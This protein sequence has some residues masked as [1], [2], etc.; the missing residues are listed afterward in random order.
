MPRYQGPFLS[1]FLVCLFQRPAA[2]WRRLE[3]KKHCRPYIAFQPPRIPL[4][5]RN[6]WLHRVWADRFCK[7]HTN[8]GQELRNLVSCN[9]QPSLNFFSLLHEYS[10]AGTTQP[11]GSENRVYIECTFGRT[12]AWHIGW[13]SFDGRRNEGDPGNTPQFWHVARA[14]KRSATLTMVRYKIRQTNQRTHSVGGFVLHR[15]MSIAQRCGAIRAPL[16]CIT[17]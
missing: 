13:Y 12:F 16:Y 6:T 1:T 4:T 3:P 14:T 5:I 17:I 8:I 9:R 11:D 2:Q 15:R 7:R 10:P